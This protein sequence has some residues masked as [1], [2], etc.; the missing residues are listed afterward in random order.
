MAYLRFLDDNGQLQT[1]VLDSEHFVIGRAPTCQL[2]FDSDMISREHLRIDMEGDGRFRARDLGSRNRSY[3]NGEL[4]TETLLTP[5][6]V[7]RV[8]DRVF[9]FVDDSASPEK[10]DLEFLTPDRTE[11]PDCE[12]IKTKTPLSLTLSQIERLSQLMGDQAITARPEDIADAALGQI[13]L[14]LQAERGLIALR[15][16]SKSDLRP[17]AHRALK[18]PSGG[19]MTPVSQSFVFAPILQSVAG[20]YPKTAGQMNT[21]L[22][23]AVTAVAAPVT[24]RGDVVGTLYVDRPSAKKPFASSALQYCAA[25]G[26]QVGALMGESTRKLARF[27]GREGATWMTIVRRL[28]AGLTTPV[29]ST[30]A[31][32]AAMKCFPGRLRCGDF[33]CV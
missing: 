13:L 21:K 10:I 28:Q 4:I 20:R 22:G 9:E 17:L 29:A 26:A 8:G 1:Q 11:P 18:R 30:D 24:F 2:S 5:G 15:G 3:V 14:D 16:Q 31:F 27:A 25:A 33:G 32:D 19:S 23:Y 12:W 6:A 7:L